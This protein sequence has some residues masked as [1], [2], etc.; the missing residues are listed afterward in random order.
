M[1]KIWRHSLFMLALSVILVFIASFF[2]PDDKLHLVFCNVGQGD[3]ILIYRRT[4]QVLVDGGPD[5]QV[6][7]CLGSHMPFWD[8]RIEAVVLTHPDLDHYGG[9]V[10]VFR[11][12]NVGTF[13]WSGVEKEDVGFKTLKTEIAKEREEGME[14][15]VMEAGDGLG[16][17]EAK[18]VSYWPTAAPEAGRVLGAGTS[19]NEYSMVLGLSY[20]QFNALLTGDIVPPA[21][22]LM[23]E[24]VGGNGGLEG[25]EVLKV[26]HHGSK[27]GLTAKLLEATKPK[28]AVISVGRNNRYGHPHKEVLRVLGE[29]GVRTLRTD[30]EGE[31]E[32]I[33]DGGTWEVEE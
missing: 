23:I 26:P 16:A 5:R 19:A 18:L 4:A 2:L 7:S 24:G 31:I 28:L 6:L 17:A 9:L 14:V 27:N 30:Q 11:A 10:A 22:D 13:A 32:I 20:G 15:I 25:I 33:T 29:M 3:A 12:Y 1:T 8:R 21:T